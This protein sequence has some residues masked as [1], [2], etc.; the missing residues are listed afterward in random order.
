MHANELWA[1]RPPGVAVNTA[2]NRQLSAERAASDDPLTVAA[3]VRCPVL[4]LLGAD[5][6]RPWSAT[7]SLLGALP[8]AD[9]I[10]FDGAGYAPWAEQP[11]ATQHAMLGVLSCPARPERD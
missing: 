9:R 1:T 7:D 5:D 11:T 8:D 6:P 4:M 3:S 2:A 10:V